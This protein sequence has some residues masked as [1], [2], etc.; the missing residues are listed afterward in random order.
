[1]DP[2][3]KIIG[4]AL[5][6]LLLF[7]SPAFAE[8]TVSE[9]A[10]PSETAVIVEYVNTTDEK[11]LQELIKNYKTERQK[12]EKKLKEYES[13]AAHYQL[14]ISTLEQ[15]IA[16]TDDYIA[17]YE[18]EVE[19]IWSVRQSEYPEASY[20]WRRL[21]DFG[22]S[23]YVCAGIL[24]NIMAEVGGNTLSLMPKYYADDSR[25]FYGICQW[26]KTYS[27][28][29]GL[30]V[31]GQ[32]D[33]LLSSIV[34]EIDTYGTKYKSGFSYDDFVELT[35]CKKAAKAFAKSYERCSE[36]SIS[37]RERN[38]VAAYQYFAS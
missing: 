22:Y 34:Y 16:I 24:G 3:K 31:E 12:Y 28:V 9:A 4:L 21:Q 13:M 32:V 8:S 26:S 6:G 37:Q 35:D 23:D 17:H 7:I 1:M 10:I 15:E 18:Q 33:F 25:S 19:K 29:W 2:S 11:E 14:L 30:N 27:D 5:A 20:V 38:A 36:S